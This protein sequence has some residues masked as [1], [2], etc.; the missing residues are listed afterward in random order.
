MIL[1]GMSIAAVASAATGQRAGLLV[2]VADDSTIWIAA[3]GDT[4]SAYRGPG[5]YVPRRDGFWRLGW[6]G[7]E[8]PA[9]AIDRPV[10]S[11]AAGAAGLTAAPL[12]R[13][14]APPALGNPAT[15]HP[16]YLADDDENVNYSAALRF[17]GTQHAIL[18]YHYANEG[19]SAATRLYVDAGVVLAL[20]DLGR[21]GFALEDWSREPVA[22]L[23]QVVQDSLFTLCEERAADQGNPMIGSGRVLGLRRSHGRWVF[24]ARVYNSGYDFAPCPLDEPPPRELVGFDSLTVAWEKIVA[25]VP[26]ALDAFTSPRGDLA[27]VRDSTG[28]Q[29]FRAAGGALTDRLGFVTLRPT[30]D[31]I[32]VQWALG[33]SV[34]RWNGI[35]APLLTAVTCLSPRRTAGGACPP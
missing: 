14:A 15:C 2:G 1:L 20:D 25:R 7:A 21:Q 18:E 4:L 29:V 28:L 3:R 24:D 23:G 34:A 17:V 27:V 5:L 31:V 26:S 12:G 13:R 19:A 10:G 30:V 16:E 35:L 9:E 8:C 11:G 22:P 32:L 6:I 33:G